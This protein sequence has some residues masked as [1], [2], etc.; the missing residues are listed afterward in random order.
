MWIELGKTIFELF[1]KQKQLEREQKERVAKICEDVS[2]ILEETCHELSTDQYP[3]GKCK[4]MEILSYNLMKEIRETKVLH[5]EKCYQLE[6]ALV[7][8]AK[9]E[10]EYANRKDPNTIIELAMA[11]GNFKALSLLLRV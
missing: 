5:E 6:T 8:S 7:L 2:K 10:G 4:V 11:S 3:H 9:L 1:S